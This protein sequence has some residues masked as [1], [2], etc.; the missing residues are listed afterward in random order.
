MFEEAFLSEPGFAGLIRN[1]CL[2]YLFILLI[3]EI[4]VQTNSY[5]S[6]NPGNRGSEYLL[7]FRYYNS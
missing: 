3:L 1:V 5:H 6:I 7:N 2:K 4:L